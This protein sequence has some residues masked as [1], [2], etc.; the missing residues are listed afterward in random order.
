MS[1]VRCL[2]RIWA[3]LTVLAVVIALA[4]F[5]LADYIPAAQDAESA[6]VYV[7]AFLIA[8]PAPVLTVPALVA[9]GLFWALLRWLSRRVHRSRSLG[10]SS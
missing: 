5:W 7:N 8:A 9:V 3:G 10:S 2:F 6:N 4:C 1:I